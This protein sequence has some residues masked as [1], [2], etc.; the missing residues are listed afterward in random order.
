MHRAAVAILA[1]ASVLLTSCND[2]ICAGVGRSAFEVTVVDARTGAALA[3]SAV[4]Y[5]FRLPELTRVDSAAHRGPER[6]WAAMDQSGRF[7]VVVERPGYL[8]WS[9]DEQRVTQTCSVNTVFL[10]ARLI[11]R[12]T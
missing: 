5:V 3:D 1:G 8:P 12:D 11:R 4:V 6:I 10:T 7:R 9:A 2:G